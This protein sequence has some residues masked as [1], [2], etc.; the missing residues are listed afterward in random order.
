MMKRLAGIG[1]REMGHVNDT[2]SVKAAERIYG[3]KI[4]GFTASWRCVKETL[5]DGEILIQGDFRVKVSEI[6]LGKIGRAHV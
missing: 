3:C 5:R 2:E 6:L 4:A 1:L